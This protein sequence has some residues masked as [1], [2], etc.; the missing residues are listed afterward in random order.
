MEAEEAGQK[1]EEAPPLQTFSTPDKSQGSKKP[2]L[3]LANQIIVP[4]KN[5]KIFMPKQDWMAVGKPE[6]SPAKLEKYLRLDL[7]N[8]WPTLKRLYD[9]REHIKKREKF[10]KYIRDDVDPKKTRWA[11]MITGDEFNGGYLTHIRMYSN[12]P[13]GKGGWTPTPGGVAL[14][15]EELTAFLGQLS[16]A[17]AYSVC[18]P[19]ANDGEAN[20]LR[21]VAHD[22][23]KTIVGREPVLQPSIVAVYDAILNKVETLFSSGEHEKVM[24]RFAPR[25]RCHPNEFARCYQSAIG[26]MALAQ[27]MDRAKLFIV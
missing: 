1:G 11:T 19:G 5:G 22:M 27:Y 4:I 15:N 3:D 23:V 6:E 20:L 24:L 25:A 7:G 13:D 21:E 10:S 9:V 2:P 12:S 14:D 8:V 17:I 26:Y 18:V 16:R